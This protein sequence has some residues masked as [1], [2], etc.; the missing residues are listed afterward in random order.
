MTSL[1][2][3]TVDLRLHFQEIGDRID[4]LLIDAAPILRPGTVTVDKAKQLTSSASLR[5]VYII[6]A[7][8]EPILAFMEHSIVPEIQAVPNKNRKRGSNG[9]FS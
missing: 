4:R 2:T 5:V 9:R 3:E 7:K 6:L 1:E 8:V